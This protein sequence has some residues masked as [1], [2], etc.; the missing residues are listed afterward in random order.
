MS[1]KNF[2]LDQSVLEVLETGIVENFMF[3]QNDES[4]LTR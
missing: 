3:E 2:Q 4:L 1:W